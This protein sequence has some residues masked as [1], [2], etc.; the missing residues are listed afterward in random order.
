LK[1]VGAG[2]AVGVLV[3]VGVVVGVSVA[4]AVAVGAGGHVP[5][6][7][8]RVSVPCRP[9]GMVYD[10]IAHCPAA[11]ELAGTVKSIPVY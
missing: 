8:V 2:P 7:A 4:A 5:S 3:A 9:V 6:V 10:G 1:L 11:K